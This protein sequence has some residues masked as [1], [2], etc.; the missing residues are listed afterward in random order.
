M[1]YPERKAHWENIYETKEFREVGWFQNR[2][3]V[4]LDFIDFL[5]VSKKAKI[6]DVGAGESYFVDYLLDIGFSD[7]HVLDISSIAIK[8]AKR[9]L[10]KNAEKV[11]WIVED[12]IDFISLKEFELW[13]DRAV[14]H[15]LFKKE[16]I[17]QY[18][19]NAKNAIKSGGHLIIGTF[20]E[21]GP[22]KCSGLPVKKYSLIQLESIFSPYFKVIKALNTD[23]FTPTGQAQNYSFCCFERL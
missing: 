22:D 23:H 17:D 5:G 18:I 8:K 19:E 21:K 1:N 2:P 20:S 7:I 16:E 11:N 15:F 3:E 10:E 9:R 13:H 14:F 12:V 4:S 6:I